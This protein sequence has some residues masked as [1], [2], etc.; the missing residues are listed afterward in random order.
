MVVGVDV[1]LSALMI[2]AIFAVQKSQFISDDSIGL[3]SDCPTA[4][5]PETESFMYSSI[6]NI[7]KN[8]SI[9]YRKHTVKSMLFYYFGDIEICPGPI[10]CF[11]YTKKPKQ[12]KLSGMS[13]RIPETCE[14][15]VC[16]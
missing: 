11:E 5:V 9:T 1:L 7:R 3:T 16:S 8:R 13:E 15:G 4:V 6:W 2:M 10:K 12:H 14:T